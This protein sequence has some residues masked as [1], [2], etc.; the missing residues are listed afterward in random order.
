MRRDFVANVSHELRTP[1]ASVLSASE[2]LRSSR[3]SGEPAQDF[4]E[5]ID[6]NAHRLHSL[7][8]D[9][10]DLSRIESRELKLAI[11]PLEVET[12]VE[13]ILPLFS[14]RA[15]KKR[16]RISVEL[17]ADAP[18]LADR[19]AL[20]QVLSN[21]IDNALKYTSER[22]TIT[23]RSVE[24]GELLIVSVADTGPGIEARHLPRLFERFYRADAGR[25]RELGGTG[26]GL[27]IVKN[28]VEAMGGT[29]DVDSALGRG[30]T[31][32]VSLPRG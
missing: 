20:E 6:R 32:S 31:F 18:V 8:E 27:S 21:L 4:L 10:L 19:R 24:R 17:A 23:I 11:E 25:S 29:V 26:L 30:A 12:V 2:T 13:P 7:V 15:A 1:I 22:S 9:L 14:D 16:V 5:I 3:I 28:L